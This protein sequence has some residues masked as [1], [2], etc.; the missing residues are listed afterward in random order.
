MIPFRALEMVVRRRDVEEARRLLEEAA[1]A[2][3]G[4]DR[5]LG[6][7]PADPKGKTLLMW[8]VSEGL[9]PMVKLLL[10]HGADWRRATRWGG[11]LCTTP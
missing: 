11:G 10:Q 2:A 3:E 1:A 9:Q 7:A 6:N 4:G 5:R 8:C